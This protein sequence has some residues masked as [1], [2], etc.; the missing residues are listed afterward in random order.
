[1]TE[2]KRSHFMTENQKVE[3]C[4]LYIQDVSTGEI[5]STYGISEY[6]VYDYLKKYGVTYRQSTKK[7]DKTIH[8]LASSNGTVKQ[9]DSTPVRD[10]Y[11]YVECLNLTQL[12]S[13]DLDYF[14]GKGRVV[15]DKGSDG[16]T[17]I[18]LPSLLNAK[19]FSGVDTA[20]VMTLLGCA[21]ELLKQVGMTKAISV[22]DY[23]YFAAELQQFLEA[24]NFYRKD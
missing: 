4:E 3:I 16:Q 15:T 21:Y 1:M 8:R 20:H 9:A 7:G 12:Q 22:D 23:R 6:T 13:V 18:Y 2:K 19:R 10:W 11:S 17:Y 24:N 14:I 5:A